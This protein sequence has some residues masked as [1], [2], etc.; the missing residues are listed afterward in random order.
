MPYQKSELEKIINRRI[1]NAKRELVES[2]FLIN[3]AKKQDIALLIYGDPLSA[4]T[5]LSLINEAKKSK[6][7]CVLKPL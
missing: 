1:I 5:H 3:E 6:E 2:D 4:T 7:R